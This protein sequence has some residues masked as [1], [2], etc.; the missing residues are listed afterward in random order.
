MSPNG[1][2]TFPNEVTNIEQFGF[3]ILTGDTE[4][5]VSFDVYPIF[6]KATIQQIFNMKSLSPT[7]FHWPDLDADIEIEALEN[8]DKYSLIWKE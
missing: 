5:F 2:N 3:W 6:K 4:Y 1:I 7:Q 8:P